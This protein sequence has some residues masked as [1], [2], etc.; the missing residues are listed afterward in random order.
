MWVPPSIDVTE[1]G[2]FFRNPEPPAETSM[3]LSCAADGQMLFWDMKKSQ[4]VPE[5]K[6]DPDDKKKKEGWGPSA[7][8]PL[9]NP[10][11]AME[12]SPAFALLDVM[13]EDE[14]EGDRKG[15]FSIYSVTEEGEF[16]KV[17]LL[18]PHAETFSKGI[19]FLPSRK[20]YV[21][22]GH[23]GPCVSLQRS[24]FMPEVHLSVGDWTFV[25]WKQGIEK[26]PRARP[27]NP[28]QTHWHTHPEREPETLGWGK[29]M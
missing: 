11:G 4:E 27:S 26:V 14:G 18:K 16:F 23:Y 10:D 2:K 17:E 22:Q 12:M 9:T 5:E 28:N 20:P 6:K 7:K 25:I 24:P 1:K 15:E 8:L 19:A 21:L 29:G 13:G 3:F